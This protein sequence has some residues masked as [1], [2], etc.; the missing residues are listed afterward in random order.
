MRRR[1]TTTTSSG[2][3]SSSA[4]HFAPALETDEDDPAHMANKSVWCRTDCSPVINKK[5]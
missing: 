4:P 2:H 5:K 1:R 3:S